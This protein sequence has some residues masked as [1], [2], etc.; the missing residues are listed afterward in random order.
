MIGIA[1]VAALR[2]H[3]RVLRWQREDTLRAAACIGWL[4]DRVRTNRRIVDAF[5]DELELR[6]SMGRRG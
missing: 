6:R 5:F 3:G 2:L 1:L 4:Y